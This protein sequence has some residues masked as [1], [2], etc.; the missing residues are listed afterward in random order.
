MKVEILVI[1]PFGGQS[2]T[3]QTRIIGKFFMKELIKGK[4]IDEVTR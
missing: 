2:R 1:N 4:T 3:E